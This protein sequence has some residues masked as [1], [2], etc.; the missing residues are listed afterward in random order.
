M[1]LLP[2]KIKAY[3]G[4]DSSLFLYFMRWITKTHHATAPGRPFCQILQPFVA[5]ESKGFPPVLE[6]NLASS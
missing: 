5:N 3:F 1:Y 4:S 6:K 2:I